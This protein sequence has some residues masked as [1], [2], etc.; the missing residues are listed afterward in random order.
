MAGVLQEVGGDGRRKL[1]KVAAGAAAVCVLGMVAVVARQES[2]NVGSVLAQNYFPGRMASYVSMF[3]HTIAWSS[4]R[5]MRL[6]TSSFEFRTSGC[7]TTP[8]PHILCARAE[9]V[10][11]PCWMVGRTVGGPLCCEVGC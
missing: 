6:F 7:P 9:Y 3:Q 2:G 8:C 1:R 11:A 5:T 10:P 4:M